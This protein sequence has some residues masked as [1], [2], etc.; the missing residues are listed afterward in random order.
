MNV[1]KPIAVVVLNWNGQGLLK[2]FL[3]SV[4]ANTNEKIAEVIVVDNNS[5]DLSREILEQ[6]FS[7][8][9]ILFF[10]KNLGYAGGYNRAINEIEAKYI[11]LLNSDVETPENWLEPLYDYAE[12]NQNVACLQPKILSYNE[13]NKFEYAGA[14]GGYI[15]YLGFPFCRG[16]ILDMVEEDSGQY[17]DIADVFWCSGAALFVDR[18]K[19]I[20]L[21]GLDSNFFAHM[22]EIDFCWRA[23]NRGYDLKVIPQSKIYHLGGGSLPMNHP[24]KLFLNYR[25]NLLMLHKNMD[26]SLFTKTMSIRVFFDMAAVAMFLLKLNFSN[27]KSVFKAYKSY[28]NMR[29]SYSHYDVHKKAKSV[30]GNSIVIDYYLKSQKTFS[31][32][33]KNFMI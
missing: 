9:R 32:I 8:L 5:T 11:V 29:K 21:G 30:Y 18:Y 33:R 27:V 20:E 23:K 1:D 16:R 31:S 17:D 19:Y 26:K 7:N 12:A 4:I 24:H 10:D 14:S 6:E 2:K 3:P 13:P 22:E 28:F 15:D 25:N